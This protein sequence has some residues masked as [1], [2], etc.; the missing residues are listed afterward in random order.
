MLHRKSLVDAIRALFPNLVF[1]LWFGTALTLWA[2]TDVDDDARAWVVVALVAWWV[3]GTRV[4]GEA[5]LRPLERRYRQPPPDELTSRGVASVLVLSGGGRVDKSG[6][7]LVTG[8]AVESLSDWSRARFLAGADLARRMG[9]GARL[10]FTGS[11]GT[12]FA[13]SARDLF[14]EIEVASEARSKETARHA[15]EIRGELG[16]GSFALVTSAFHMIRALRVFRRNGLDPVPYPCGELATGRYNLG[17]LIPTSEGIH[18]SQ[19]AIGEYVA[20][21]YD[22]VIKP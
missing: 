4:A 9:P 22:M 14:P 11:I 20:N 3:L 7:V 15:R 19:I 17:D 6:E 8:P 16:E 1:L 13:R 2:A 10:V 12:G 5:L 18:L 21:L